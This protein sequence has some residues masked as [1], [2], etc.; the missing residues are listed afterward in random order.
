MQSEEQRKL[1][2]AF[3]R[4]RRESMAP[5][6]T[7]RRRRTPGLRR[8]ELAA[9]AAIGA[10]WVAWIEQGRD[11]RPSA[12]TLSRLAA[13]LDLSVAE[14]DY[15]FSLAGR[16]DPADPFAEAGAAAPAAIAALVGRI[17]WPCYA[18]DPAWT[19]CA[20]NAAAKRLF[21]GLFEDDPQPNLLR[22]VFTHPAAR[23]LLP[24][25]S[26]RA[27]RLLAEF[28]RDYSHALADPRVRGVVARLQEQS[29][30][31]RR[32]WEE[33]AVLAR[34]GGRRSFQ[35]PAGGLL[36]FEQHTL[37]DVSRRDFRVV[38]LEPVSDA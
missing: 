19:L 29:P 22:Y 14:R 2:G 30:E 34:E 21:T 23:K 32:S 27:E 16:H 6:G 33:Q 5:E 9:R 20:A 12:E 28:R 11:V 35:P 1:L 10:T 36:H 3:V 31:F 38:F 17:D 37:T 4:T 8:E 26:R 13:G 25:W 24:D 15:L 7:A 18:L